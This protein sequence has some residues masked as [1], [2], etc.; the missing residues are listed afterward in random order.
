MDYDDSEY[1]LYTLIIDFICQICSCRA[2]ASLASA[3]TISDYETE[4]KNENDWLLAKI[5]IHKSS[6]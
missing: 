4:K 3:V 1:I 6:N 5:R 2:K